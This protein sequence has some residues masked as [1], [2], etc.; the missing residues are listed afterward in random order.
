MFFSLFFFSIFFYIFNDFIF[1][2]YFFSYLFFFAFIM[3]FWWCVKK[4]IFIFCCL[5]QYHYSLG[6]SIFLFFCLFFCLLFWRTLVMVWQ[7][8]GMEFLI[9]HVRLQSR[10]SSHSMKN[11]WSNHLM[12]LQIN[13]GTIWSWRRL[14]K[15]NLESMAWKQRWRCHHPSCH[16]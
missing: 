8:T 2:V 5:S 16:E 7:T 3:Q 4:T 14:A 6:H 12:N 9:P 10:W 13:E 1:L 11:R 15:A